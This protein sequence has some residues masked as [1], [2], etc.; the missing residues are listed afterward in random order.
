MA[1]LKI[2]AQAQPKQEAVSVSD[3][4]SHGDLIPGHGGRLT[5]T[6]DG[7]LL[8]IPKSFLESWPAIQVKI[9]PAGNKIT[10]ERAEEKTGSTR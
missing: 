8:F 5:F 6:P 10:L 9:A 3:L 1:R 2:K 7:L 4:P